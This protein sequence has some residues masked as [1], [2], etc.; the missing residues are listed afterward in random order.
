MSVPT[1]GPMCATWV[2]QTDCW[3]CGSPIHVLQCTC[4][5]VVLLDAIGNDWPKH[6]CTNDDLPKGWAAVDALRSLG[7]AIDANI[8]DKIFGKKHPKPQQNEAPP[9][10]LKVEPANN[11]IVNF[12]CVIRE[13][14]K[15]SKRLEQ[16]MEVS[17]LGMKILKIVPNENYCQITVH[18]TDH[19]KPQSYTCL[20]AESHAIKSN[21]IGSLAFASVRGVNSGE[22]KF[23]IVEDMNPI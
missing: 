17:E 3:Y 2:F 19:D 7:V 11:E 9:D 21:D 22:F 15:S 6:D 18:T 23:W 10:I 5:S 16:L 12:L 8:T 4:G 13:V 20:V 1:H 14:P